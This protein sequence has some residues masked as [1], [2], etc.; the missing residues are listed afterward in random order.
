[1]TGEEKR[2]TLEVLNG[3][4]YLMPARRRN[5]I[6]QR[7][8]S[9]VG[10]RMA[11]YDNTFM[12][13]EHVLPQTVS[14]DSQ[15][16]EWWP[17]QE[18]REQWLHRLANLVPLNRKTNSAAQNYDFKTKQDKYFRNDNGVSTH[19]L[20]TWVLTKTEWSPQIVKDRQAEL[21]QKLRNGWELS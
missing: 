6:L 9:F 4:V 16:E 2:D 7:L 17:D 18:Q 20:T 11:T 12:S 14:A 15:W 5:F 8:D 13:V 3:P 1:L 10:D 19:A 21:L